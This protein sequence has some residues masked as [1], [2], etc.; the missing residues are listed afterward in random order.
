MILGI[1]T[2]KSNT[3]Y[4]RTGQKSTKITVTPYI[5]QLHNHTQSPSYLEMKRTV[6]HTFQVYLLYLFS[7]Y[8]IVSFCF[9]KIMV[10]KVGFHVRKIHQDRNLLSARQYKVKKRVCSHWLMI[11]FFALLLSKIC[12]QLFWMVLTFVWW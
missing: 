9:L 4:Y 8:T 10:E 2:S 5:P 6:S 12:F 1:H 7:F 11:L 3:Q